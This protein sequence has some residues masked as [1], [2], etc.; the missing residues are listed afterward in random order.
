MKVGNFFKNILFNL[1]V[2][3]HSL[4]L[5]MK[6]ADDKT[7]GVTKDGNTIDSGIEEQVSEDSVYADLLRGE[8]TQEVIELRDSNYRG[9]KGSF[10]YKYLGNGNVLKKNE[11]MATPQFN[12]FNP[13]GYDISLIQDNKLVVEGAYEAII[14]QDAT[15]GGKIEN[16]N[17]KYFIKIE[18]DVFPR[19]LIEKYVKKIVVRNGYNNGMKVDLYCSTYARQFTPTDSLFIT[20]L[21]NIFEEKI[22]PSDTVM[23]DSIEFITDGCYGAKDI[24]LYVLGTPNFESINMYD[25]NF[26]LTYNCNP[27]CWGVDL[28]EKYRTKEMDKKYAEKERRN[29]SI[30]IDFESISIPKEKM[31]TEQAVNLLKEFNNQ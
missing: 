14:S 20:E 25:G 18:R 9:Y 6:S 17:S 31:D 5:G 15:E 4:F 11:N 2:F 29:D 19:F 21:K 16:N 10:D 24:T 22:R 30:T 13:E 3:W 7:M 8:V 23:I 1:R 26:V 12:V 28:T 27:V